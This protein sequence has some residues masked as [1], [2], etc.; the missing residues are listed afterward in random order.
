M[1]RAPLLTAAIL[2]LVWFS[3]LY[4]YD[5]HDFQVWHTEIQEL[6]IDSRSSIAMEEELRLGDNGGNLYYQYYDLGYSYDLNKHFTLG[7]NYRQI[8]SKDAS[9]NFRQEDMPHINGTL[10]A[11]AFGARIDDRSRFEYK[12]YYWQEDYWMYRNKLGVKFPWAWT[13]FKFQPYLAN[14]VFINLISADRM[15]LNRNRFYSGFGFVI[16]SNL[17][18]EIYYLWQA[19]KSNGRWTDANVLGSKLKVSF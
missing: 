10:K 3:R 5:N 15:N 11:E 14:E 8:F 18:G 4:A 6:K 16:T 9:G 1:P 12:H 7:V 17:K 2:S 13:K 19:T